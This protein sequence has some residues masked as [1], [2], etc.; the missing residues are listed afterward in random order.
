[1]T[2]ATTYI[3]PPRHD[4]WAHIVVTADHRK[5]AFEWLLYLNQNTPTRNE[6]ELAAQCIA[7]Q[8]DIESRMAVQ[9]GNK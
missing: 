8:D 1:M 3:P 5:R 6:I 4:R 9:K 2:Q 7:E